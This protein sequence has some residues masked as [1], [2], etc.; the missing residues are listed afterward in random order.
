[1]S[2]WFRKHRHLYPDNWEEIAT[3]IKQKAGWRCEV[4]QAPHGPPP[5]VL[6]TDHLDF[7]PANCSD[8]NLM[9]LCQCCH[10]RRQEMNPPLREAPHLLLLLALYGLAR[11]SLCSKEARH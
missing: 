9:A 10:L 7:N 4:C 2:D 3:R 6:T 1:V 5:C 11:R 8:D